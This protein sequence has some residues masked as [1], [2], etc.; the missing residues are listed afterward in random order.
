MK[1]KYE[2]SDIHAIYKFENFTFH[3]NPL[4]F[5]VPYVNFK[6]V[7]TAFQKNEIEIYNPDRIIY[8]YM[9]I[10][11]FSIFYFIGGPGIDSSFSQTIKINFER[12]VL[13]NGLG[14]LSIL[15]LPRM[16]RC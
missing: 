16:N 3:I 1:A 11:M 12:Y 15:V 8:I 5:V 10:S 4:L 9:Y 14:F 7:F 6:V 2:I 13:Y